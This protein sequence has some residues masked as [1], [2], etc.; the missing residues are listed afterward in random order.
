[1]KNLRNYIQESLV[2]MLEEL[3]DETANDL[4]EER[5]ELLERQSLEAI[6]KAAE[7][8]TAYETLKLQHARI[9][10]QH[11]KALQALEAIAAGT[12]NPFEHARKCLKEIQ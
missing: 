7:A 6:Q 3:I 5:T 11:G 9:G 4:V 8:Q 2:G 1:M 12:V 10:V